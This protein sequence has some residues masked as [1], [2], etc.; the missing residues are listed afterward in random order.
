M[1]A[2]WLE[3]YQKTQKSCYEKL[4]EILGCHHVVE[5]YGPEGTGKT[6]LVYHIAIEHQE[7]GGEVFF[8]DT[9]G[10]LP[11]EYADRLKNYEYIDDLKVLTNRIKTLAEEGPQKNALLVVDSIGWPLYVA[12]KEIKDQRKEFSY[13][14][15]QELLPPSRWA[16]R[17]ARGIPGEKKGEWI[18]QN[19]NLT[20]MTDQ[21]VWMGRE[22]ELGPMLKPFGGKLVFLPALILHTE[23]IDKSKGIFALKSYK[24]FN[25]AY[26][27]EV[28]T[29]KISDKGVE[30]NWKV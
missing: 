24:Y 9:E 12:F 29:Y 5:I 26:G 11:Y 17:F 10:K 1:V 15:W 16:V 7:R 28:A 20:I 4:I 19:Q 13:T 6:K 25:F 2:K 3:E 8:F 30:V 27:L 22:E 18:R 21:P 23:P 14:A